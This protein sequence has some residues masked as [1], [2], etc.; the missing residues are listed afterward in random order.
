MLQVQNYSWQNL[1]DLV[2][3]APWPGNPTPFNS[4]I[5]LKSVDDAPTF[6]GPGIYALFFDEGLIYIGKYRGKKNNPF[7]GDVTRFRW[8]KHLGTLTMRG[9]NV[10]LPPTV[11]ERVLATFSGDL[12]DKLSSGTS[13]T[14]GRDRGMVAGFKRV[15]FAHE[16][17]EAFSRLNNEVL[18]RFTAVYVR[19]LPTSEMQVRDTDEIRTAVS[20]AE[21][22]L[23][24]E[25]LPICNNESDRTF[26]CEKIPLGLV[27]GRIQEALLKAFRRGEDPEPAGPLWPEGGDHPPPE[28]MSISPDDN[29]R[30]E[31]RFLAVLDPWA[32]GFVDRLRECCDNRSDDLEVYF[33]AAGGGDLRIRYS[34]PDRRA[35]TLLTMKWQPRSRRLRCEVLADVAICRQCGFGPDQIASSTDSVMLSRLDLHSG[36]DQ[37]DELMTLLDRTARALTVPVL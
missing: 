23:I 24:K 4:V 3:K 16:N 1:F 7:S 19:V 34:V 31:E 17:W 20:A 22:E 37:L 25:F 26:P 2:E 35:R 12:I 29:D 9:R 33:T 27:A 14:I 32:S 10:S 18:A 36:R 5:R 13:E 28:R 30:T 8:D 11:L 6:A 15:R 21:A